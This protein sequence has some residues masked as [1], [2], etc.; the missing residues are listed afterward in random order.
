MLRPVPVVPVILHRRHG[1][2]HPA[3]RRV[4][5][6][7]APSSKTDETASDGRTDGQVEARRTS[8]TR[9]T[10]D[11]ESTEGERDEQ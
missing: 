5:G 7:R 4:T 9:R 1:R 11:P 3:R 2:C 6:Y 8:T 10:S